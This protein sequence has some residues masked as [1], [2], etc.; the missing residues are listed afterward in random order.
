VLGSPFGL[1]RTM[2]AVLKST[3][4]LVRQVG[5]RYVPRTVLYTAA[6]AEEIEPAASVEQV[7]AVA[8]VAHAWYEE[9]QELEYERQF[10]FE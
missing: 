4:T 3:A 5:Y 8:W 1:E 2:N 7:M 9:Q 10:G 6:D